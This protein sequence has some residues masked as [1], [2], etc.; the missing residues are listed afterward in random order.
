MI[1]LIF[2]SLTHSFSDLVGLSKMLKQ[3]ARKIKTNARKI[4]QFDRD[5]LYLFG[6]DRTRNDRG[7]P[8]NYQ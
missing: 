7:D 4:L 8:R 1:T 2:R 3:L 6:V 5:G